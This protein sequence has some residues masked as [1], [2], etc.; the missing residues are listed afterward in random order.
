MIDLKF[1]PYCGGSNLVDEGACFVEDGPWDGKQYANEGEF[2]RYS[3]GDCHGYFGVMPNPMMCS[4]G[5]RL[6]SEA[7]QRGEA[8]LCSECVAKEAKA[9]E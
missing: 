1:C 2:A 6:D 7:E 9:N 5:E 3:C 4:C 8:W